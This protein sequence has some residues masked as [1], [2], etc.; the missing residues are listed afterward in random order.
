MGNCLDYVRQY[1]TYEDDLLQYSP[2]LATRL[3]QS[4]SDIVK[5][6][7][8]TIDVYE[9]LARHDFDRIVEKNSITNG[10]DNSIQTRPAPPPPPATTIS[11]PSIPSFSFQKATTTTA[12]TTTTT[13]SDSTVSVAAPF[14]KL[15]PTP[16]KSDSTPPSTGFNFNLPSATTASPEKTT[17]APPFSFS[18][19]N[20]GFGTV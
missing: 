18:L 7:Q 11:P 12:T 19:P 5:C 15:T 16:A 17:N 9:A 4:R 8:E 14:F 13:S 20:T 2:W 3:K 10:K 6:L 1:F